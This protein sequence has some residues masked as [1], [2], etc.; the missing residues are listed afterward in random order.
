M[1]NVCLAGKIDFWV[2][3]AA[4]VLLGFNIIDW[5]AYKEQIYFSQFGSPGSPR[6][7]CQ[8]IWCLVSTCFLVH[9]QMW[10]CFL[11]KCGFFALSS[12]LVEGWRDLFVVFFRKALI[13]LVEALPSWPNHLPLPPNTITLRV[14]VSIWVLWGGHKHLVCNKGWWPSSR[15]KW[16]FQGDL[17]VCSLSCQLQHGYF[18]FKP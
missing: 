6:S 2:S 15:M 13:S 9:R 12:H 11:L 8:Q 7:R 1:A 3:K 14:R 18:S 16:T 17:L 4:L 10:F 5:M